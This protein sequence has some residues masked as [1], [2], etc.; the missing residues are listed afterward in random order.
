MEIIKNCVKYGVSSYDKTYLYKINDTDNDKDKEV[1]K[2]IKKSNVFVRI[3]KLKD[4]IYISIRGT[5]DLSDWFNNL[6]RWKHRFLP[7]TKVHSGFLEHLNMVY[8]DI[9]KEIIEYKKITIIGH[10]LGGAVS[11]LLGSKISYFD[12]SIECNVVTY[13]S[14][15]VGDNKF[16]LLCN[17]LPNFKCYRVYNNYDLITKVPYF[18]FHHIG[19]KYKVTSNNV[20]MYKIKKTHSMMTYMRSL[21]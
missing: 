14:P 9:F 21:L 7:G 11:V 10:S 18:G 4:E 1:I 8:D 20:S 19:L 3:H 16:K 12:S 2:E 5:D 6:R 17:S 13:G 15:R